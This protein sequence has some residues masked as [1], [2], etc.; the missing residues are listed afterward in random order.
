MD[1]NANLEQQRELVAELIQKLD[2]EEAIDDADVDRLC[3]LVRALDQWIGRGGFLP[4]DWSGERHHH[5]TFTAS[6]V[7]FSNLLRDHLQYIEQV[8]D[9]QKRNTELL[10]EK[11][12][13]R[14]EMIDFLLD[15]A[16][17][18]EAKRVRLLA[19][20]KLLEKP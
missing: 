19:M 6:R 2:R 10:E 3:E 12:Q 18:D 13:L 5:T 17:E 7:E 15:F 9:L 1:P 20:R 14:A 16:P 11:R 4:D 8:T